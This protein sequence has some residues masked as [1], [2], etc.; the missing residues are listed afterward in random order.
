M[1]FK[2]RAKIKKGAEAPNEYTFKTS[3]QSVKYN[4]TKN[5]SQINDWEIL[6]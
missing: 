5:P 4:N 6:F 3:K 2:L 1:Y